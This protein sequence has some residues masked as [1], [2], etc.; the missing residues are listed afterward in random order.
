MNNPSNLELANL[1][2]SHL[3][4]ITFLNNNSLNAELSRRTAAEAAEYIMANMDSALSF[5][6]TVKLMEFAMGKVG[7]EGLLL[8]FGVY[9]GESINQISAFF[10]DRTVYGFDS[11]EGL[12]EDWRGHHNTVAGTF[13]LGGVAPRVNSNVQLVKG[14]FDQ[15]LPGYLS[16]HPNETIAFMHVDS[17]TYEAAKTIFDLAGDRLV[18]GSVIV[19][20][21]Y[22]N[23]RGW[24]LGEFKAWKEFCEANAVMYEYLGFG[25]HGEQVVVR[26]LDSQ[27]SR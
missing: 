10:R 19:F 17:D 13:D 3:N 11:F 26:I 23:F 25:I 4:R 7:A 15:T 18:A 20:D 24:R 22:L 21:E 9:Q 6:D 5:D 12:K 2:L 27:A 16:Q 1:I 8:E 14:W